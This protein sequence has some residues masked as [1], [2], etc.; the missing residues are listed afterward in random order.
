VFPFELERPKK[1]RRL[2]LVLSNRNFGGILEGIQNLK[3]RTL[4]T[5]IYS[6]GLW[7]GEA[8][9][10]KITDIDSHNMRIWVRG[11]K[12]SKD[13]ITLLSPV[14]LKLLRIYFLEYKPKK[15]LFEGA[16]SKQ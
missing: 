11:G 7:I 4:I 5:T 6:V 2:P 14:L 13:R 15:W 8:V 12:G 3:H 1:E 10:L 16:T 9:N